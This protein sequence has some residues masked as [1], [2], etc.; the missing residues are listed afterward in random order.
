[1]LYASRM[2]N[3]SGLVTF[4]RSSRIKSAEIL[5]LTNGSLSFSEVMHLDGPPGK[6]SVLTDNDN[7]FTDS[8]R[9]DFVDSQLLVNQINLEHIKQ[10][11]S[12]EVSRAIDKSPIRVAGRDAMVMLIRPKDQHR[13]PIRL[14]IDEETGLI[15]RAELFDLAGKALER[16]QF[17]DLRVGGQLDLM[18]IPSTAAKIE[19]LC[20]QRLVM[21]YDNNWRFSWLPAN[22]KLRKLHKNSKSGQLTMVFF[23]GL[24][25]FSIIV[26]SPDISSDLPTFELIDGGTSVFSAK[27][28]AKNNIVNI[29]VVGEIPMA[30]AKKIAYSAEYSSDTDKS[31]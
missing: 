28:E 18:T 17:V 15:L 26:E 21:P 7:C 30:T 14:A 6:F 2:V 20:N 16:F 8:V 5:H 13:L 22:F 4:E 27:V 29:S 24:A 9:S 31:P 25:V 11:Y 10:S 19:D 23:D 1:M 3:Y 12:F